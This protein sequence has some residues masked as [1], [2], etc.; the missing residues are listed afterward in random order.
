MARRELTQDLVR[1]ARELFST[2]AAYG[3]WPPA[4]HVPNVT[5]KKILELVIEV[6]GVST[7]KRRG[8]PAQSKDEREESLQLRLRT[9]NAC[10]SYYK[11]HPNASSSEVYAALGKK[12]GPNAHTPLSR[13][14]IR[15][16][17]GG[18]PTQ[19]NSVLGD[20]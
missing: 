6:A 7:K 1:T 17:L 14:A 9:I 10:L 8:R 15:K 19:V 11:E 18:S 16:R 3:S 2:F 5:W 4:T 12:L 20:L 13:S